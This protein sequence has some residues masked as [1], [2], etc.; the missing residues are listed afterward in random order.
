MIKL[1]RRCSKC[2]TYTLSTICSKC[3]SETSYPH[4]PKFSLDDK[5][6]TYR[7]MERYKK[8]E[9]EQPT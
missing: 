3:G 9:Q 2:Q 4:P 5:Y 1:L 7:L 8:S 6:A